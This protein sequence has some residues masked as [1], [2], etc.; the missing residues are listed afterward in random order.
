MITEKVALVIIENTPRGE[1][2][3]YNS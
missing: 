3:R 2:N 1:V